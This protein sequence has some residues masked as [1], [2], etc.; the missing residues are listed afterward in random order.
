MRRSI[1]FSA[2]S[3][4]VLA[5]VL[6][7]FYL[8]WERRLSPVERGMYLV[9]ALGCHDCHTPKVQ[10]PGGTLFPDTSR[11]LS[12]HP[13]DAP[14]PTWTPEDAERKVLQ[15]A[16]PM[17]TAWAGPW[18][19]SFAANLTPDKETGLGEW[20]KENFI[21]M[22]RTGKSQRQPTGREVLPPMPWAN[23]RHG[24]LEAGDAEI[25]ALWAYLGSI[26][27]VKNRVPP[28]LPPTKEK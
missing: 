17:R 22:I 28:P 10:G 4:S 12:G 21:E 14:Y 25:N 24:L 9:R 2:V 11:L 27:P 15:L 13:E 6:L 7:I 20:T 23:F 18:G 5:A 8:G 1:A 26:P 16:G 3:V 19:V